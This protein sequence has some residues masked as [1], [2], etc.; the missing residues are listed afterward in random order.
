MC[1][2]RFSH[3]VTWSL[4]QVISLG[5]WLFDSL[6]QSFTFPAS[7]GAMKYQKIQ[8]HLFPSP[9]SSLENFQQH[10]AFWGSKSNAVPL[11]QN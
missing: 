4:D 10:F 7:Q 11:V 5:L 8:E 1:L 9:S 3:S 6:F 2:R